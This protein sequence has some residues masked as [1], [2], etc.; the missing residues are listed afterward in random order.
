MSYFTTFNATAIAL[1]ALVL[2]INISAIFCGKKMANILLKNK[3]IMVVGHAIG[4]LPYVVGAFI[5]LEGTVTAVA[6]ACT[7]WLWVLMSK[8]TTR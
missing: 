6:F 4:W 2:T 5:S 1:I 8:D 7:S 3:T